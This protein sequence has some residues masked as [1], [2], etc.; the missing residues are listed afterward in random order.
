MDI[1]ALKDLCIHKIWCLNVI[2]NFIH[3]FYFI[4]QIY[5][6]YLKYFASEL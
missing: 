5:E 1:L 4:L 2:V 6:Y 3:A